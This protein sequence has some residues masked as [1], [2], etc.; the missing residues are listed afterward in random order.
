MSWLLL[1]D[2][3]EVGFFLQVRNG[4]CAAIGLFKGEPNLIFLDAAILMLSFSHNLSKADLA[5]LVE[6]F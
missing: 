3:G 2:G 4:G 1:V 5:K 6:R